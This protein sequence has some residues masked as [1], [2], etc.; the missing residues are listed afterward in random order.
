VAY[1]NSTFHSNGTAIGNV[2]MMNRWNVTM[3]ATAIT[4]SHGHGE[5][6]RARGATISTM[7]PGPCAMKLATCDGRRSCG[8]LR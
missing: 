3:I 8:K 1:A 7:L 5:N 6:S 4:V 2:E